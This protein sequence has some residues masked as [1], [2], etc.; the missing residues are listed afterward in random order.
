MCAFTNKRMYM[1]FRKVNVRDREFLFDHR[2]DRKMFFG[3]DDENVARKAELN[4]KRKEREGE[5]NS[6][7]VR[8]KMTTTADVSVDNIIASRQNMS[9]EPMTVNTEY[10]KLKNVAREMIRCG[11]SLSDAA[12]LFNALLKDLYL[13]NE[14]NL[15]DRSQLQRNVSNFRKYIV[16][17]HKT[18][19][20]K[21]I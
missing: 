13:A 7:P 5:E 8:K 17:E 9:R 10:K 1:Y 18:N 6:Q 12:T 3:S 2:N 20:R 11:V 16:N 19:V 21:A 14:D 4:L 15:I